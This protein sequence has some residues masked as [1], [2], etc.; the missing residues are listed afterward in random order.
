SGGRATGRIAAPVMA[1]EE[2]AAWCADFATKRDISLSSCW[3]YA[4]SYYDLPFLAALG[5]PVAVNPDR[6]LRA[7]ALGRQWPIISFD[8]FRES[9]AVAADEPTLDLSRGTIDGAS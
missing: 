9:A 2:K 5:H 1:A 4:D 3:G 7:A 8:K 6:K